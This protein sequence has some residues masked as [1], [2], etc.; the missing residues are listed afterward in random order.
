LI[1]GLVKSDGDAHWVDVDA[2]T[3]FFPSGETSTPLASVAS[4]VTWRGL[5]PSASIAQICDDPPRVDT[6]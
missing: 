4:L 1:A 5:D 6:K 3:I 2:N